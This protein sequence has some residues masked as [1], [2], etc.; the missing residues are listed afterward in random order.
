MLINCTK[1]GCLQQTEA[2]LNKETGE[3]ICEACENPIDGVTDFIK[4]ALEDAKQVM[5]SPKT[6]FQAQCH[7]CRA[8]RP[9][10]IENGQTFCKTCGTQ[11]KVTAA[12]L[13]GLEMHLKD[14]E[15]EE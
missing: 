11:V 4:K 7:Q 1:K 2:K 14:Q 15:K 6:A 3:V 9:L 10:Y 5:R 12:F 8:G 13:K